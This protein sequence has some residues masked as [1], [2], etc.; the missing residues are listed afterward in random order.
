MK[1][2]KRLLLVG[3]LITNVFILRAQKSSSFQ[4]LSDKP[5][6]TIIDIQVGDIREQKVITPN[7]NE[8]KIMLDKGTQLLKK[9]APDLPKLSFSI[10]IPNQKNSSIS[11]LES[12][13][14]DIP[15][16][17]IAPSK[18]K[19]Y[20]NE[21][22]STIPFTYGEEYSKNAFF[23]S[24]IAELNSPYIL[25][26]FRGQTVQINP[27][28]YN[29]NTK[30][31]R[32][33]H[34][35]K[36]K[37]EYAGQSVS[38]ILPD[39]NRPTMVVED[40]DAIYS[41]HF[42]NYKTTAVR[43]TPLTQ[44]GS[45]LVLCPA[46]YLPEIAP[47]IKWKEMKGIKTYLVNTDTMTGGVDENTV[48]S[49]ATSYYNTNQ[50][51]YMLIVGDHPNVP[52]RNA[53]NALNPIL[54]GPSDNGYAYQAGNDHYP[55]FIVGRFSGET[56]SDIA[57]QVKRTL[58]YEKTPNTTSN[59]VQKQI[60]IAS[61][62]GP[63]DDFQMDFDHIRNIL[64]SNK[65]QYNYVYNYEMYDGTQGGND[66]PGSPTTME[67]TN[68]INDGVSLINY[69]GHGSTQSIST[70]GFS[71]V[72]VANLTNSD[73]KWPFMFV[74]ACLNGDFT[75]ST[76]FAEALMREQDIATGEP[77][78]AIATL[79]STI[80][81]SWD[82][83]MQGQ[84]EMNAIMRG[85]RVN[86][87]KTTFGALAMNGCMSVNDEYNTTV[88]P[89][90]G[91]E[92]T[93]TWTVF[94]DPTLEVRTKHE[95]TIACT[96]TA[97]IGRNSTWYSVTCPVNGATIGLYYQGKFLA[98][99][100]VS[101]GNATFTFPSI[102]ATD[103][104]FV[105]ATKQNYVPYL[106]YTKVVDF[107]TNTNT[108]SLDNAINIYPNPILEDVI[109]QSVKN[110]IIQHVAVTDMNGKVI[111]NTNPNEPVITISMKSFSSGH[112][113]IAVKTNQ[114]QYVKLVTKD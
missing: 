111:F 6:Q 107:P 36:V 61:D 94:G 28:Q 13:Y 32:V 65:N 99:S 22:P 5:Y 90:G 84:D 89:D 106:G 29:P 8:V 74:T 64:D 18:G 12:D 35:I 78:G 56:K 9:G 97:E 86:N 102:P 76:C 101:N 27:V 92:I 46:N 37:I 2:M 59:W 4:V 48:M 7:G 83:P 70:T 45:L 34:S 60:G 62:Q 82:P 23:P 38:N 75:Q 72:E 26:D 52:T 55:E 1:N 105:T 24:V 109:I 95:G 73:G 42:L 25:R 108:I 3:I 19:I 79:M 44:T 16:V 39:F 14:T 10:I 85:A 31:L 50:I 104:L 81:Q 57:T 93:D 98:V 40:Y 71:N 33:Y 77:K 43:Y 58:L 41:N 51:A 113:H 66:A 100:T 88:D 53:N 54:L 80:L 114:G 11:I 63:G 47:Y 112:Y 110:E 68:A 15:N 87:K 67:L 103:T 30:V 20:R 21:F 17:S 96:H 49:L 91:N 69:C